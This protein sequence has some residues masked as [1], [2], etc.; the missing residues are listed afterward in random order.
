M[1][2]L[3]RLVYYSETLGNLRTGV[4]IEMGMTLSLE[5]INAFIETF[6]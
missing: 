4:S 1:Y 2:L 6:H 3:L 5:A